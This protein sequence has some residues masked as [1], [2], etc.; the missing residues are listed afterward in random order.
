MNFAAEL[1]RVLRCPEWH[2]AKRL[3]YLEASWIDLSYI[4]L[5][6]WDQA[7]DLI[8]QLLLNVLHAFSTYGTHI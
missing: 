8:N 4:F 1:K 2:L 7:L 5:R 3:F 6:R